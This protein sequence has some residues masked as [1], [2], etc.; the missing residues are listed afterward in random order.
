[1]APT[2]VSPKAKRRT[3]TTEYKRRILREA[4]ACKRAG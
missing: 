1:M 3:F 4:D 2:E